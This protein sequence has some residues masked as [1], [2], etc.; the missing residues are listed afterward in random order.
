METNQ[1]E[2]WNAENQ[3]LDESFERKAMAREERMQKNLLRKL[4]MLEDVVIMAKYKH[5]LNLF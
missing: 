2:A 4:V 5:L 3:R 1:K